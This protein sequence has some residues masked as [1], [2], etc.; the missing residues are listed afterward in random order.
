MTNPAFLW[1]R[2]ERDY[3]T[4]ER[5]G[6]DP[7]YDEEV[8]ALDAEWAEIWP[9]ISAG[10]ERAT[11]ALATLEPLPVEVANYRAEVE[12]LLCRLL[13]EVRACDSQ[14]AARQADIRQ[15]TN[16]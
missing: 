16:L 13:A 6:E 4:K 14:I 10:V 3:P 2:F 11:K 5:P 12:K 7:L 8:Q 1:E 9:E 15:Y